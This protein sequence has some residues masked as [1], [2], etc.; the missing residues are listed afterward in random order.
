MKL[1]LIQTKQNI[2]Y[3]F[4][5]PHDVFGGGAAAALGR[6]GRAEYTAY[7]RGRGAAA[8]I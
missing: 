8:P 1:G 3:D 6:D 4:A 2:L 7:K 5:Y